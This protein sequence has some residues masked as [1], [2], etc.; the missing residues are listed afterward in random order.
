MILISLLVLT[1]WVSVPLSIKPDK[2]GKIQMFPEEHNLERGKALFDNYT[3]IGNG[4]LPSQLTRGKFCS[5]ETLAEKILGV[6]GVAVS[7]CLLHW[8]ELTEDHPIGVQ[9]QLLTMDGEIRRRMRLR[10]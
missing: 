10:S 3:K 7:K 5:P 6:A 1:A 9:A 4:P 2:D 8:C